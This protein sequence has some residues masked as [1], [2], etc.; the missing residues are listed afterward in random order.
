MRLAITAANNTLTHTLGRSPTVTDIAAYLQVTEEQVL[1]GLEGE[2]AYRATSLSAPIGATDHATL[3]DALGQEDREYELAEA[4]IALG[5]ALARLDQREQKI[6]VLRFYG[7][8]T[9]TQIA[10]QI[11]VS[12]MHVS[13]LLS[14]ALTKLRRQLDVEAA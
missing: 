8:L 12:Q 11:G 6:I 5:P 1:E 4:R 7:N 13:R 14:R 3:A 10:E 9:Q 2:R